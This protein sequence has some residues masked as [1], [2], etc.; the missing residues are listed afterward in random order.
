[1]S[2]TLHQRFFK[3]STET[4]VKYRIKGHVRLLSVCLDYA[5]SDSPLGCI[6]DG[7]RL[8][9]MA[10]A[11]GV[12]DIVTLY[13]DNS[14]PGWPCKAQLLDAIQA[15]GSRCVDGDFFVF[16]F[17][18][19]GAR[20][21]LELKGHKTS[22][23]EEF[24]VLRKK[25]GEEELVRDDD[26]ISAINDA[27]P[28]GVPCLFIC[29]ACGSGS[30]LEATTPGLW[31][32]GRTVFAI[33]GCGPNQACRDTGVGGVMTNCMFR[34]LIGLDEREL[35]RARKG[36]ISIQW[37]FNRM[38]EEFKQAEKHPEKE[39]TVGGDAEEEG[40][41]ED[42][43]GEEVVMIQLPDGTM[44]AAPA[45]ITQEALEEL[46]KQMNEAGE[47]GE[48]GGKKKKKKKKTEHHGLHPH[49]HG[50]GTHAHAHVHG[51]SHKPKAEVKETE[52]AQDEEEEENE[53]KGKHSGHGKW[54]PHPKPAA[55]HPPPKPAPKKEE[56]KHSKEPSHHNKEKEEEA[57]KPVVY[58]NPA[59]DDDEWEFVEESEETSTQKSESHQSSAKKKKHGEDD[60]TVYEE[61]NVPEG[62][63]GLGNC[64]EDDPLYDPIT[65]E[66]LDPNQNF[67]LSWLGEKDPRY[68]PFPIFGTAK[69]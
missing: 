60:S 42:E 66:R 15:I 14:T 50:V 51:A 64:E 28:P 25:G 44:A 46:E 49:G 31:G 45:G 27:V 56:K 21:K 61:S 55:H 35:K 63:C 47:T 4:D 26:I 41:E 18:G 53:G 5:D 58:A 2:S 24:F 40:E 30:V 33:S 23:A 48:D 36:G 59:E 11:S 68:F 1:M 12:Q 52:E 7:N 20:M 9:K 43:E 69:M 39:I 37:V 19:H 54:K 17:S 16:Q 32:K 3:D 34:V 67:Y 62:A 6:V 57:A 65:G 8:V 13:D 29:D 22:K 10:I 38:V